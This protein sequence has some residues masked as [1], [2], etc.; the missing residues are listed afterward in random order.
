[1]DQGRRSPLILGTS[2][3]VRRIQKTTRSKS[4]RFFSSG[5]RDLNPRPLDPQSSALPS[6]AT[7]RFVIH[8][9]VFKVSPEH[10]NNY[11]G[12]LTPAQARFTIFRKNLKNLFLTDFLADFPYRI[13]R[14]GAKPNKSQPSKGPAQQHGIK[15]T[16]RY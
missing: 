13:Q 5:W 15:Q 3:W 12:L 1:M 8:D 11:T 16:P 10:S 4:S 6:C 14:A 2:A 9:I 7:T